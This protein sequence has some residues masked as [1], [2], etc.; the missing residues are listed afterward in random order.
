MNTFSNLSAIQSKGFD[1]AI[2]KNAKQL[3]KGGS[4]TQLLLHRIKYTNWNLN[5]LNI[6]LT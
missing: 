2:F 4:G 5:K 3:K 1:E 6:D